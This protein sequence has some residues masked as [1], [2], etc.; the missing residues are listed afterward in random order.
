MRLIPKAHRK[1]FTLIELLVAM[2]ISS[3]LIIVL[4]AV[5]GQLGQAYTQT[6]RSI[7]AASQTRA[8]NHFFGRDLAQHLPSSSFVWE[9]NHAESGPQSSDKLSFTKTLSNHEQSFPMAEDPGDL[10]T[11]TYFVAFSPETPSIPI[12]YRSQIGP[13]KTQDLIR[14]SAENP[15]AFPSYGPANSEPVLYNVLLFTCQPFF[16]DVA[17]ALQEWS[18]SS[19]I[20][21]SFLEIK[22]DFIDESSAQRFTTTDQWNRLATA[23][24]AS[25]LG[26]IRSFTHRFPLGL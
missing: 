5:V 13:R 23:P 4:F 12:L 9:S 10:T 8:F 14:S 6:Q 16:Y 3:V 7:N 21:P 11:I 24:N 15:A 18:L 19:A 2:T 20:P 26:L 22:I 17:G 25:Q 1:A